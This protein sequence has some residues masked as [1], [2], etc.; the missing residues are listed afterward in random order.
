[1]AVVRTTG[2]IDAPVRSVAAAARSTEL[3]ERG[4]GPLRVRG[5]AAPG[6]GELLV[7]GDEIRF[8]APPGGPFASLTTRI[9]RADP[10]AMSSVVVAGR[11]PR[12]R[13]ETVF[14]DLG[15]RT[16]VADALCWTSPLGPLGRVAD[17]LVVR[18]FARAVLSRRRAA[19]REL[20][21]SWASRPVVVGTAILHAGLL[22]A[23]QRRYPA[24]HAGRWELPGGRVEPGETEC[25]AV[26]RECREELDVEVRPS[27]RVGTDVPLDAA[28]GDEMVLRVHTAEL[29]DPAAL[30]RAVEHRAVRWIGAG[31]VG[32]LDWLETDRLLAHSLRGLLR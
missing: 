13:H 28:P 24:E 11:V 32:T 7:P 6:T 20:A 3:A 17:V 8:R 29:T 26:V 22:L 16:R 21:V 30:P 12:L 15:G 1:M 19:V 2:V 10:D 9:V 14:T 27:G 5:R 23:Q 25:R 18:R 4:P 31:E